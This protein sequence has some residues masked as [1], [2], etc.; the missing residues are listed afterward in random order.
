[1]VAGPTRAC[2]IFYSYAHEDENLRNELNKHLSLLKQQQLITDWYD[3]DVSAGTEWQHQIDTHLNTAHVILLL[4]SPNFMASRYCSSVEMIFLAV[5]L[6]A[7]CINVLGGTVNRFQLLAALLAATFCAVLLVYPFSIVPLLPFLALNIA[8]AL[9][10]PL[11]WLT[12]KTGFDLARALLCFHN[13]SHDA[14]VITPSYIYS[15]LYEPGGMGV[16]NGQPFSHAY[17]YSNVVS[18][19][20]IAN[21]QLKGDWQSINYLIVDANMLKEIRSRGQYSLL[22]QALHHAIVRIEY[23]SSSDGTQI[24][25]YQ[26][27]LM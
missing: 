25:I 17:I 23:G 9:N 10:T 1:M 26:A 13:A 27:I 18:D 12:S 8:I 20:Q 4:I 21:V 3:R 7:M 24:Q 16:G 19:S 11:R 22:N 14:V 6:A 2:E 5:G 15:D